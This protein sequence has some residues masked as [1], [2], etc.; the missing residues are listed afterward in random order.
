[1]TD[2][3]VAMPGKNL[4]VWSMM[5]I[6]RVDI[7]GV[8]TSLH[9]GIDIAPRIAFSVAANY[10]WQRALDKTDRHAL[11]HRAT[12]NHQIPY[13]PRHSGSAS[14]TL[15]TP[16]ASLAYTL[17]ASGLRYCNQYN[18]SEYLMEGYAEHSLSLWREFRIRACRLR[19]QA[20]AL[21][22]GGRQYEI[23]KN[24]PMPGRQFR[25]CVTLQ[26]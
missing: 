7:K 2:K 14:A 13:T 4:F 18:S 3:I 20:E 24:Y 23:V 1:M 6:G 9:A 11:P 16:W 25:A 12:F 22:V 21:N 19:L 10:T 26:Y 5:N 15:E 8:E 17:V